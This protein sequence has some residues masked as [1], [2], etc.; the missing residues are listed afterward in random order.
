MP[1]N[2]EIEVIW[3]EFKN[4]IEK[5]YTETD[6]TEATSLRL[7]LAGCDPV[8]FENGVLVL[9]APV[10]F[11]MEQIKTRFLAKMKDVFVRTN[12]GTDIEIVTMAKDMRA[13]TEERVAA[14]V[15]AT[16]SRIA[17]KRNGLNPN[18]IF[19]SFVVG[20][21]NRMA[22]S[23]C[24]SV[25]ESPGIAYNPLFI[26][27]KVG[28]GKT[29][30]MH[31]IGHHIESIQ[32]D[33]KVLYVSAEKFMND[34]ITSIR[35]NT[36]N[37]FRTRYRD[38]DVLM[39]DDV[40]FFSGKESTQEEFYHTFNNLHNAN[41]QLIIS[42]DRPPKDIQDVE[43]RLVSRFNWGLVTDIQLP[44]FETRVAILQKKTELKSYKIPEEI[45]IF[46]AQNVPSNIREL[47][48]TL[49]RIVA[50][51]E[52]NGEPITMENVSIWLKDIIRSNKAGPVSIG[53]IQQLVAESFGVSMEELLSHKRT[54]E[55][56]L[57]RQVAMYMSRSK[58]G[59]SLQSISYA[60]N[61]KDHTTVLH[62]CKKVEE[63][64]KSDLR[65]RSYVDNI[66]A[67]L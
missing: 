4:C 14:A 42:S 53:M 5:I 6:P 2:H 38:L 29:H 24:L 62:A 3:K 45:I 54:A 37:E 23:A 11:T 8:S 32:S 12:F 61:K 66:A 13:G 36:N 50:S 21:S 15:S 67:K 49:N 27:G 17:A 28:L 25:A 18:Y 58:T 63:I 20:P 31:A 64:M 44:D 9:D 33:M 48:G 10:P 26:W 52:F 22:H 19:S 47:E 40:Q 43:D 34:F 7:Y 59:E 39:I 57:A 35:N 30:L 51:A 56:A 41:K 46:I 65:I 55:L 60:F 1:V 16:A